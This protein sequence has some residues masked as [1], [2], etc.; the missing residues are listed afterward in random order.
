[1]NYQSTLSNVQTSGSWV[2]QG[3]KHSGNPERGLLSNPGTIVNIEKYSLDVRHAVVD[4]LTIYG[5][6][7]CKV[8][9]ADPQGTVFQQLVSEIGQAETHDSLGKKVWDIKYDSSVNQK[10]GTRSLT[11]REFEMHTDACFESPAPKYIGMY[12]VQE[13]ALGGGISQMI[14]GRK[15]LAR[16][17]N[18]AKHTLKTKMYKVR[19]PQEFLKDQ[20]YVEIPILD[21]YG[22][23]RL[24]REIIVR[25]SCSADQLEAL[26]QLESILNDE[27]LVESVFL[28][29]GW[30]LL[31]DNH[32][33]FHARTEVKDKNRHLLRMRFQ[34]NARVFG[35]AMIH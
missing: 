9:C 5:V 2:F 3:Y 22:N 20:D 32:K 1:M 8:N 29:T 6:A 25:E 26:D 19:V 23:F 28:R 21:S 13:D 30:M 33:L 15:V 17:S 7:L 14:D 27:S 34:P 10:V 16:L 24:R 4:A 12:V 11:L 18:E 31:L 35:A